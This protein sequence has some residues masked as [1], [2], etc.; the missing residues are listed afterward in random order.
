MGAM[1]AAYLDMKTDILLNAFSNYDPHNT[2]RISH[3]DFKLAMK[4]VDSYIFDSEISR[5]IKQLDRKKRG[6][7]DIV[8]FINGVGSEYLKK[9]ADRCSLTGDPLVW[10]VSDQHPK[11]M[12]PRGKLKAPSTRTSRLRHLQSK[13]HIDA[14]RCYEKFGYYHPVVPTTPPHQRGK[15]KPLSVALSLHSADGLACNGDNDIQKR[16]E[17]L[18]D[19][20]SN[21]PIESEL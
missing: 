2:G 1:Q 12:P 15:R 14:A 7:I 21:V 11:I 8:P 18:A 10:E 13:Q 17:S 4:A 6:Y 16:K 3:S 9:K 19:T 5:L 20:Q